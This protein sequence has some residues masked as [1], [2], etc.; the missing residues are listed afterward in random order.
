MQQ[1]R[2]QQFD[3]FYLS[4]DVLQSLEDI[5]YDEPTEVQREAIPLILAGIDLIVQSQTGTGKT[6]ACAI[7]IIE[8]LDPRPGRVEVLVMAPTRELAK[9]VCREFEQIGREKGINATAI[10]GGT[11][12]EKQYEALETAQVVAATPGRL[13]DLLKKGKIDLDTL[14]FFGLDEADE[15]L[16]MGFRE[17]LEAIVEYLPEERQSLLFS[18]TVTEAI[19]SLAEGMLFYP[20]YITLSSDSVAAESVSHECFRVSGTRKARDLVRLLQYVRPPNAIIFANTRAETFEVTE[21]LQKYDFDAEVLNGDL[22][23]SER[24]ETLGKL[25]D[26]DLDFLVATD[27]AA[28]GIDISDLEYVI[29]YS[30]PDDPEVYIHR[31]GRTGRIG[32]K[33]RAIS[34]VAPADRAPQLEIERMYDVELEERAFPEHEELIESGERHRLVELVDEIDALDYLPYGGMVG[35]AEQLLEGDIEGLDRE[36]LVARLLALTEKALSEPRLRG[37]LTGLPGA[38]SKP[39]ES[40]RHRRRRT[41]EANA[42]GESGRRETSDETPEPEEPEHTPAADSGDRGSGR[43]EPKRTRSNSNSEPEPEPES[44]DHGGVDAPPRDESEPEPEAPEPDEGDLLASSAESSPDYPMSKMYMDIGHDYF[45]D[46][47]ELREM[48]CYMSGMAGED[49]GEIVLKSRYSFVE[50]REDYFYDI[51]NALNNQTYEDK[52]LTAEP[53]RS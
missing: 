40:E 12:Y 33:G 37:E 29:N 44:H 35:M 38:F 45:D 48:L 32:K 30:L 39:G 19:K 17:E 8:M 1:R 7:P 47:E 26:S 15:M 52:T 51:I 16:S 22:P 25:R 27:V 2:Q 23:Q 50:V 6:A 43:D 20:E 11:S 13:L 46:S 18:A 53:A 36:R 49:F 41:P 4:D 21:F 14:R 24:E 28:R 42:T 3:D 10:Y 9:Q 5:D 34:L 31:T